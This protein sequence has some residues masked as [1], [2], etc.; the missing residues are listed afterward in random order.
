MSCKKEVKKPPFFD[1]KKPHA[2]FKRYIRLRVVSERRCR[3]RPLTGMSP[4][5]SIE[6][7]T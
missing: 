2:L 3:L 4:H 6:N 5:R 7:G 1:T